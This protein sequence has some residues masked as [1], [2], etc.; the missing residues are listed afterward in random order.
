[1]Y[2]QTKFGCKKISSSIAIVIL[3]SFDYTIL[4]CDLDLKD[5]LE[6]YS[7]S[8]RCI[9]TESLVTK[10]FAVQRISSGQTLIK[11]INFSCDFDLEHSNPIFSLDTFGL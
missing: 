1:M 2:H 10:G 11:I 9:T 8:Q 7:G 6:C 3:K 4:S 5:L